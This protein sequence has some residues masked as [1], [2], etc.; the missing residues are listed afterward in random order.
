MKLDLDEVGLER[1]K[2]LLDWMKWDLGDSGDSTPGE[3]KTLTDA[4]DGRCVAAPGRRK[5]SGPLAQ[6]V[7]FKH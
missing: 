1:R 6:T 7:S 2:G 5:T 3:K 4:G